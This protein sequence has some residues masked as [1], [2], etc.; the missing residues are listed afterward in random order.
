MSIIDNIVIGEPLVTP[1]EL[2][3]TGE[4]ATIYF[5]DLATGT[6]ASDIVKSIDDIKNDKGE[7]FLPTV[8]KHLGMFKSNGEIRKIN[9]QRQKSKKFNKDPDQDLWRTLNRPEFT[10]FKIGKRHFWL[11]VGEFK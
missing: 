9:Q 11:I 4:E 5:D 2:G 1:F 3:V 8:L 10:E 7:I 6:I